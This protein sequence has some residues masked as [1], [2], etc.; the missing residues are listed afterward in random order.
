MEES[1][2]Q[3]CVLL[4]KYLNGRTPAMF[5]HSPW[6]VSEAPARLGGYAFNAFGASPRLRIQ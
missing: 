4:W 3:P 6:S 2:E 5:H 1:L